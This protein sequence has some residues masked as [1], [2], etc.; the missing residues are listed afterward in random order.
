MDKKLDELEAIGITEHANEPRS[1]V[2]PVIVVPNTNGDICLCVDMRQSNRAVKP[3]R[4]PL[5]TAN[6]VLYKMNG[7]VA[8]SKLD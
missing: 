8:F 5:P 1:W 7:S 3:E 2:S 4:H 6:E